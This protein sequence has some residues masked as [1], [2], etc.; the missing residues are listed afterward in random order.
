MN[1]RILFFA[2]LSACHFA[3]ADVNTQPAPQLPS[4]DATRVE[5]V[6]VNP[7]TTELELMLPGE[8]IGS[9]DVVMAA[10]AG[11]RVEAV[12]VRR[13]EEVR[14][15]QSLLR[16]DAEMAGAQL[17]QAEAREE[18]ARSEHERQLALG[19]LASKADI[20]N[21]RLNHK[22]T[23]AS[24]MQA[25]A[26]YNRAALTAPFSGT[27]ADLYVETGSYAGPGQP[28][29]RLVELDTVRVTLSVADRDVVSLTEGLE[30]NVRT[31]AR[32]G[33]FPGTISHVGPAADLD[34]RAFPVEVTVPN[35][36]RLLLPG[37]IAQVRAYRELAK[38]TLIIPQE[39]VVT[40]R[41]EQGVFI[42]QDGVAQWR[43]VQ[44][45]EVSGNQVE[46]REGLQVGDRVII[47]GQRNLKAGETLLVSRTGTC[48]TDGR[49][50]WGE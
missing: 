40:T 33:L 18:Q 13:G 3:A 48:C 10:P 23:E 21:A 4:A 15:G 31:N 14:K 45:G 30:V 44:L 26:A 32:A 28:V 17:A 25:Q 38:D 34:T 7:S 20:E 29:A 41:T 47:T 5:V 19:D 2:A 42:E 16:V 49:P 24:M 36:D 39:W 22:V 50:T 6:T 35:P 8:V 1:P 12:S 9:R 27:V 46:V 37:M 43:I 11:G